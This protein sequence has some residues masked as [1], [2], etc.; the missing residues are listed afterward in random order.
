MDKIAK[1]TFKVG[2]TRNTAEDLWW[3]CQCAK[4]SGFYLKEFLSKAELNEIK[5]EFE[6]RAKL[7]GENV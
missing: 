1:Y 4:H 6:R 5:E 2:G 7:Q 3:H